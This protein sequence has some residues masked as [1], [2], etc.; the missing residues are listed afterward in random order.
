MLERTENLRSIYVL[1]FLNI[2]FYFLQVNDPA[3]YQLL[4]AFERD[5][6]LS[7]E[8]WRLVTYQF[9]Q[10]GPLW[11]FFKLLILYI[12]G[13]ALEETIGTRH[14]L[15]F[16][17]LSSIGSALVALAFGWVL[18]GSLFVGYALLFAYAYLNPEHSFYIFFVLPVKVK[19][20]AW[21][22]LGF[23]VLTALAG[24]GPS[25]AALIGSAVSLGYLWLI[26]K[27]PRVLH[28][29][30]PLRPEA[31]SVA[32]NPMPATDN[33]ARFGWMKSAVESGSEDEVR[34]QVEALEPKVVPGVNICPPADYKPENEDQ[35][36]VRCE[37]FAECSIR[38]MK[39][40]ME[41]RRQSEPE[42]AIGADQVVGSRSEGR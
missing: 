11:L 20:L 6:V 41:K 8:L 12:M 23:A 16:F 24:Y 32:A 40:Q 25:I 38:W 31:V 5:R 17:L 39:G 22:A 14:F 9:T 2:A 33:S 3:K 26:L 21:I 7:G 27:R 37:G 29:R 19:W 35:Y 15:T 10:S 18:F 1:L 34:K 36:C 4:F 28:R 30:P 42:E 13:S